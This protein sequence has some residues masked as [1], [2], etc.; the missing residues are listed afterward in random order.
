VSVGYGACLGEP[1]HVLTILYFGQGATQV[2]CQYPVLPNPATVSG[3]IE[4][5]D[6]QNNLIFGMG[7][8]TWLNSD[9]TCPCGILVKVEESTW[10]RIKAM[11]R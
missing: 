1:I 7:E 2:C 4:V 9:G 3:L 10:G 6:C 11:Y 8:T 5:V